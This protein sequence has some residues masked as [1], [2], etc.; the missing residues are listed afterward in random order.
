MLQDINTVLM[1]ASK[2][3]LLGPRQFAV[4][5]RYLC[6]GMTRGGEDCGGFSS[7]LCG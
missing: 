7:F 6:I 3:G 4:V 2:M 5:L 1:F